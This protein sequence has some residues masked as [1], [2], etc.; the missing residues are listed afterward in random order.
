MSRLLIKFERINNLHL[1]LMKH[2]FTLKTVLFLFLFSSLSNAQMPCFKKGDRICFVG[3][4]ITHEGA[5]HHTIYHYFVTRFPKTPIE[6]FNCGISGDITQGIIERMDNDILIHNPTHA[7]IMIGMNDIKREL[8]GPKPTTNS[9]TLALRTKALDQYKV[10]LKQIVNTFITRKIKV[11]L[12]K[13]SIY[14]QTAQLDTPNALGANDALKICADFMQELATKN[15]LQTIDYWTIMTQI[16][17]EIQKKD[18]K[19]TIISNDRI[20]P[21]EEGNFIMSYQFLKT[22]KAPSLVS[23]ITIENNKIEKTINCSANAFSTSKDGIQF[24]LKENALP[25]TVALEQQKATELVPFYTHL[26]EEKITV[27][28]L[29]SG[30]YSLFIDGEKIHTFSSDEWSYGI[31]LAKFTHTP[32]YLQ[33]LKVK[34]LLDEMRAVEQNLRAV[35]WV[36][37]REMKG[38]KID[39]SFDYIAFLTKLFNEKYTPETWGGYYKKQFDTYIK[40]KGEEEK[41]KTQKKMIAAKAYEVAQPVAHRIKIVKN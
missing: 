14:D 9:D 15:N 40:V 39:D 16:T 17:T 11:I 27:K 10:N 8:Y 13:P 7:V 25:F 1:S 2:Y 20:H 38:M 4:S 21:Y 34:K 24:T 32:Q 37:T 22:I 6:F 35:K 31:N 26:N 30:N 29:K 18:P 19:A 23:S 5:F 12:Q 3:N 33:A 28:N 36:E 41:L